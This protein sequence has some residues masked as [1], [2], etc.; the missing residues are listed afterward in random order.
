AHAGRLVQHALDVLGKDVQPLG[1]HDHLLL[2]ALDEDTSLLVA[3]ADVPGMEPAV[4]VEDCA[5]GIRL[6]FGIWGLGFGIFVIPARD[7]FATHENLAVLRDAD[8]DALDWSAH[9][10]FAGLERMVERDDRR[11]LRQAVPLD[12]REAHPAPELF[13]IRRKR[14]GADDKRPEL[15]AERR[16]GTAVPP[17]ASRDRDAGRWPLLR[18]R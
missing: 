9:R 6:G 17:P 18:F 5:T 3:F 2:A 7:V 11:G 1:R 12:H 4:A 8:L 13:E 16:V 10:P 14:R 15:E